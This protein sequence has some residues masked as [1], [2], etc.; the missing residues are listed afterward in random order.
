MELWPPATPLQLF[1][2]CY[3]LALAS[4]LIPWLNSEVIVLSLSAFTPTLGG[5]LTLA[6]AATVG[7][8]TGKST[9]YCAGR[10]LV[11][12]PWASRAGGSWCQKL[13]GRKWGGMIAVVASSTL[14]IPP[15]YLV[16]VLAD[17]LG[18][19]LRTFVAAGTCGR[20]LHYLALV[21]APRL[22]WRL[23]HS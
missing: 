21:F 10:R 3:A 1:A 14:G 20:L 22:L 7:Q 2:W 19:G 5:Q 23:F 6:L 13:A 16:S 18:I 8:M 11:K 9:L 12:F 17:S 4:A 15:F